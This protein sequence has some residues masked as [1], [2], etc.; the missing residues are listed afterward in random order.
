[1]WHLMPGFGHVMLIFIW[2]NQ[3]Q[4]KS[5]SINFGTGST[6]SMA[7]VYGSFVML[8]NVIMSQNEVYFG[9]VDEYED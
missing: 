6:G 1:M 4:S 8:G 3:I 7:G 9:L 5:G 2:F